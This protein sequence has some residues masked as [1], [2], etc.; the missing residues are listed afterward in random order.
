MFNVMRELGSG[1]LIFLAEDLFINDVFWLLC[2]ASLFCL[3]LTYLRVSARI[4][5]KK[6]LTQEGPHL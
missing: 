2:F 4:R 6:R 3:F 5:M 1:E